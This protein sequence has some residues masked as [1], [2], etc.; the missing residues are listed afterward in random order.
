MSGNPPLRVYLCGPISTGMGTPQQNIKAFRVA[1]TELRTLG[2]NVE[3]PMVNV[4]EAWQGYMRQGIMQ[5][6]RC[7]GVCLL[8]NW[9]S[10]RG[11]SL[12]KYIA[13]GIGLVVAPYA[14]W[15]DVQYIA[16]QYKAKQIARA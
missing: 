10:S 15:E 9:Q 5:M 4:A 16:A 13:D 8:Q 6:M 14:A 12:E 2:Y 3:S 1:E 7:D 11:A